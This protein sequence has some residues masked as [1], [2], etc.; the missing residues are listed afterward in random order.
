MISTSDVPAPRTA[1][2]RRTRQQIVAA[3]IE[4]LGQH[5]SATLAEIADAAGV[6]RSTV[7]RQF[8]DR[9]E[10]LTA[11]DD[12]CR[13]RFA[14]ASRRA[15][16]LR[17]T[18]L[19][20]LDRLA[21]EYLQLGPVLSLIFADNALIDPDSWEE[22]SDDAGADDRTDTD[23]GELAGGSGLAVIIGRGHHDH[24][25]DPGLPTMWIV[26]TLWVLLFGAWQVQTAGAPRHEVAALLSRT[27]IGALAP[28]D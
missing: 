25:I 23:P 17:G 7:H 6:S 5:Q 21:Q 22:P 18:G 24:S 3:A 27:V 10:L 9:G 4:T 13:N 20:A 15:D 1:T 19:Q 8:A 2:S 16:I 12:E 11:V 26:T 28:R 14:E